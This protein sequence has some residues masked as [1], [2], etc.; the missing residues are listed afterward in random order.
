ML[1]LK[2]LR[3]KGIGRFVD[4]QEVS[5]ERFGNLIQV[6]GKNDN[7]GGSSGA[8]KS[9]VFNAIDFLFGLNSVSNS[10][11]Q[12]RLTEDNISVEGEFDLDGQPLTISRGKKLKIEINGEIITGSSK[13]TE[14][15]LDQIIAIPRHLF[16]PMLHKK[17]GEKG[18]FLNFTPSETNSFLTDCLGLGDFKNHIINLDIKIL[19]LS[20]K[21]SSSRTSLESNETGLKASRD[22]SAALG[23]APEKEVDQTTVIGLKNNMDKANEE[24]KALIESQQL[25]EV[26]F[27]D[28]FKPKLLEENYDSSNIEKLEKEIYVLQCKRSDFFLA[29]KDK[30]QEKQKKISDIKLK[31]VQFNSKIQEGIDAN[32]TALKLANEILAIRDSTCPKCEQLWANESARIEENKILEEINRLKGIII[33]G[34]NAK[35]L[36]NASKEELI[37][38]ESESEE[39]QF[40]EDVSDIDHKE[41]E[42]KTS[43]QLEKNQ[44]MSFSVKQNEENKRNQSNFESKHLEL[45][46]KHTLES[47]QLRGQADIHRRT[48]EASTLKLKNYEENR[49]RYENSF[50]TLKTQEETYVKKVEEITKELK[51]IASSMESYEELKKAIKNYL[52]CS[53]DEAL[54]TISENATKLIQNIPNMATATIQLDGTKE[55]KEGKVKE[56]V[57]SVIHM[58]GEENIPIKTLSGGERAAVDIAIDLAV[59]GYIEDRTNKGIDTF[60]LD[61][62]FT[63][64]DSTNIEM[65]LEL[66]KNINMHKKLIV[67]DHNPIAK[68]QISDRIT[69]LRTGLTS[70]IVKE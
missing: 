31:Q 42:L 29:Q 51:E 63:G 60:I 59:L 21:I 32:A 55:T 57:N 25:E 53:F 64:L 12:S 5:F 8:G 4:E 33:G 66:L 38:I 18:F 34:E 3:F 35:I 47:N 11:L 48:F 26:N 43:L 68:E 2:T 19:D 39:S 30:S 10:M 70:T 40:S 15:K 41:Q 61:E 50:N 69:V 45:R 65:V 17:Q 28:L 14:E 13:I 54:L 37:Y 67:V 20:K 1:K 58:D 49:K 62:P 9:T 52:S 44:R 36:L 56:E 6:D 7:T 24:L 27:V 16:R 22:A 23:E 46:N